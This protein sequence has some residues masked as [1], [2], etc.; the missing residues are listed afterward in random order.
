[1]GKGIPIVLSRERVLLILGKAG[2][3]TFRVE[4]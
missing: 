4:H 2:K 3:G 1:M